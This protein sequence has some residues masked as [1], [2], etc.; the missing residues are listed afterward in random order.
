MQ[1]G[2]HNTVDDKVV[3]VKRAQARGAAPPSLHR[4]PGGEQSQ[5]Q[6]HLPQQ[7]AK[8]KTEQLVPPGVNINPVLSS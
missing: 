5:Q 4:G 1:H 6:L 3:D 2:K 8:V 7:T